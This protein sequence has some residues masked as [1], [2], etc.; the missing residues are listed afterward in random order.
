MAYL[1]RS[2]VWE[3]RSR[4]TKLSNASPRRLVPLIGP[5]PQPSQELNLIKV[6]LQAV[7]S[8]LKILRESTIRKINE[9][10]GNLTEDLAKMNDW[11][12]RF[13]KGFDGVIM[14]Q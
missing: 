8:E 5:D 4:I 7:Q 6:Q 14:K 10:I 3:A 9:K 12:K 13:D 11:F 1:E 2:T